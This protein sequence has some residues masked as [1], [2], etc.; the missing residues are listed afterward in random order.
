MTGVRRRVLIMGAAGRDFHNF[1]MVYR[2]DPSCEVKAF[3]AT[4]IPFIGRRLYPPELSGPLYPEGIPIHGEQDLT[5][6][7]P[8]LEIN[9]VVFAYSDVSH[10]HVMHRAS[11][12]LSLGADFLLLGPDKTM[13]KS[14]RPVIS[15]CAVRTG[16]GKSGIS[17]YV[18]KVAREQG[19]R[20]V[21]IRHPMPYCDLSRSRAQRFAEMEDL[22]KQNCT[23]EEREEYEPLIR[24]GIM[25][26]GGVDYGEILRRA[27]EEADLIVWDGGNNDFPFLR[28]DLEIVLLDP[29]RPGDEV[30]YHPGE[31]NLLRA[32]IAVINKVNTA[33]K[34][35]I[36]T[37]EENV[38]TLNPSALIIRTASRISVENGEALR[39]KRVLVVED[40]P[41]LT[42]GGMPQG[43][44]YLA[45]IRFGGEIVD[46]RPFAKGSIREVFDAYPHLSGLLPAMG[47]SPAQIMELK[48]T[49]ES[50]PCDLV[51]I[52]TP[53]DLR[54]LLRL[55]KKVVRVSY[56]V[57]EVE[58]NGLRSCVENFIA[59]TL[60]EDR[61][62]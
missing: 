14:Q 34:K 25:V 12:C 59:R 50:I 57:E 38:R 21:V 61:E 62:R 52:A 60:R 22:N 33:E 44:G 49:I 58:G 41:S 29:H 2:D 31:A 19:L 17:R 11:L 40:G 37:V 48:E 5:V 26:F 28:P 56:E 47:Y 36:G 1:N 54:R 55:E 32:D 9:E 27:E 35:G 4:Q 43:A 45:A 13:L 20:P 23:I 18:A 3:T 30:R 15:V 7:I 10:E 51:L 16:C 46:P 24:E 53:F 8:K 6:L 42:H 39:G